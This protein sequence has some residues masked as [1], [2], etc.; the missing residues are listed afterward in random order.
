LFY[1]ID[2]RGRDRDTGLW[3]RLFE[4]GCQVEDRND[5]GQTALIYA[6]TYGNHDAVKYLLAR[7]AKLQA[8]DGEGKSALDRANELN[9]PARKRVVKLLER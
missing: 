8:K 3:D 6:A 2:R 1:C 9:E 4:L 7:G 5:D